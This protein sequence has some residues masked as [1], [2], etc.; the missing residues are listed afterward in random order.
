VIRMPQIIQALMFMLRMDKSKICELE[1]NKL[2]WK[3][4]KTKIDEMVMRMADYSVMGPK[5]GE[6]KPYQTLNYCEKMISELN[7]RDV[8]E[9]SPHF[10]RIYK[11]LVAAISLRKQE[12]V[13]RRA[14]YRRHCEL[15]E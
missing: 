13:R 1:S 3:L 8:D 11:W 4:A 5:P 10:G 9:Y 2:S 7:E 12:I 14:H 6:Y 15:R